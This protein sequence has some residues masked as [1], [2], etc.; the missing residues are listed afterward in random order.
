M[1]K[2]VTC[3]FGMDCCFFVDGESEEDRKL[4]LFADYIKL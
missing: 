3:F 2:Y 4:D 1:S